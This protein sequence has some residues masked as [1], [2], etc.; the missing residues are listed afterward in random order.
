MPGLLRGSEVSLRGDAPRP[1]GFLRPNVD[2]IAFY[3]NPQSRGRIAR[4][5]LEEVGVPYETRVL[6][7][8]EAMKSHEYLAINPMGKV[9]C[10]KGCP[11]R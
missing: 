3:T 11:W 5:M 4:W 8:G 7:Y 9:P 6:D 2:Q 1:K 10:P